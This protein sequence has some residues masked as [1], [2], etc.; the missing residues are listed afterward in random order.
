MFIFAISI[1]DSFLKMYSMY[2]PEN[3]ISF[4][5]GSRGQFLKLYVRGGKT[6]SLAV[7]TL[8]VVLA[9]ERPLPTCCE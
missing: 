5:A 8:E 9:T 7:K 6:N 2:L 3:F 4:I 1:L